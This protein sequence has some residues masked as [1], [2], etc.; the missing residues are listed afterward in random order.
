M[1]VASLSSLSHY[2]KVLKL[3]QI[4]AIFSSE[5]LDSSLPLTGPISSKKREIRPPMLS[6]KVVLAII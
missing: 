2:P 5:H 3:A 1:K 4:Q 6:L